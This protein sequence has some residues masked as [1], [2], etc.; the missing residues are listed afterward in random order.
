MCGAQIRDEF[1]PPTLKS[2]NIMEICKVPDR[3]KERETR[4][5]ETGWG[6]GVEG[7]ERNRSE[8]MD[9]CQVPCLC[10]RACV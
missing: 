9:V 2:G 10:E 5:W 6:Y 4:G 3:E 1:I 8:I 7:R